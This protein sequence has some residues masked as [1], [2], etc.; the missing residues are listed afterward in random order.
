MSQH[1]AEPSLNEVV[2]VW[3]GISL[4]LSHLMLFYVLI[5]CLH[6]QIVQQSLVALTWCWYLNKFS[7]KIYTTL[8]NLILF[9]VPLTV[10]LSAWKL[11][12]NKHGK[13]NCCHSCEHHPYGI[14][15]CDMSACCVHVCGKAKNKLSEQY[16]SRWK[17][18]RLGFGFFLLVPL[19]SVQLIVVGVILFAVLC[20][21]KMKH[22]ADGK[23]TAAAALSIHLHHTLE[24]EK[25]FDTR[26]Y[27]GG[28]D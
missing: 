24:K 8:G 19:N 12:Y 28:M 9:S 6:L 7:W 21:F 15:V 13:Y 23:L 27:N 18:A 14:K 26:Y 22:L 5:D 10:Q 2:K 4:L 25:T 17:W 11:L 1:T 3:V 16:R 20:M